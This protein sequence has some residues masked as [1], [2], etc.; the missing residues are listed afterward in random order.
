MKFLIA[1]SVLA[2]S[3]VFAQGMDEWRKIKCYEPAQQ[4]G[5]A[6]VA[7]V[8]KAYKH[9]IKVVYPIEQELKLDRESGCLEKPYYPTETDSLDNRYLKF[10]PGE[11]QSVN[12]LVPVEVSYGQEEQD[13]YCERE[14]KR[15]FK[16]HRDDMM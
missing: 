11:G 10:C 2:S 8:L 7:Y 15:Y 16:H 1:L 5:D 3:T 9:D 14:I 12:G 4:G 13:V 6:E